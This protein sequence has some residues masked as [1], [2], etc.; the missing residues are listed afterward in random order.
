MRKIILLLIAIF[1]LPL[2]AAAQ[3]R[4]QPE[5]RV[6]LFSA[7]TVT[8]NFSQPITVGDITV[9]ENTPVVVSL[10]SGKIKIGNK[11]ID[12]AEIELRPKED[13]MIREMITSID[14]KKYP[15]TVKLT[16]RSGK[17]NVINLTTTDEYL[18][19]VIP[20]EMPTSWHAEALKSQTIAARTFA[21]QNRKRHS[22]E[23][24]D[25]CSTTHCQVYKD[26]DSAVPE[27]D[28]AIEATFGEVLIYNGRLINA[29]FHSD[30]GGMTENA[31]DVWGQAVPYL[32]SVDDFDTK[33][34]PW[35]KKIAVK[36]FVAALGKDIGD[37]KS[38]KLSA[39]EIGRG[40]ADRSSS[41][42]VKYLIAVGSKG[43][44]KIT[45]VEMRS[46]FKLMSTLFDA[47][48]N[49]GEI[50]VTG[51]GFGHGVG[52]AQYGAKDYADNGV[53]YADI[54]THYYKGATIKKAYGFLPPWTKKE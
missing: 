11:L 24:Y 28:A 47:K 18:R 21:L 16:L 17:L 20:S 5:L 15:G 31:E 39:L 27:A 12:G 25:V 22:S 34:Y 36:D 38:I 29:T 13:A 3:T 8:L 10:E 30:S 4:W 14:G 52:M 43:E 2:T 9:K 26:L 40:A 19:G 54:V 37:L 53:G 32:V 50:E 45:G 48:L 46:K 23:G 44:V 35:S 7:S 1:F 41:G 49:G 51:F 33:T 42:R 6:G